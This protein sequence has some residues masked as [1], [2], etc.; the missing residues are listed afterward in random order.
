[1]TRSIE[2]TRDQVGDAGPPLP[3]SAG[4][5]GPRRRAT[6]TPASP[7]EG[8]P[9]GRR[10][11]GVLRRHP[12]R[13][14]G[15]AVVVALVPGS[16]S[17]G[18]ALLNP[19]LGPSVPAR[20]AEWT[21]DHGGSS[22][23]DGIENYW[24]SHHPPPVG[25]RPALGEIPLATPTISLP[26]TSPWHLP[27]P[28][29][30]TPLAAP[31]LPDE[32]VWHPAGRLVSGVPAIYEAFL[33]PD[34]V[35]TS[36]V[37][38]VAW[39]D[40]K[41]LRARL[42]SGSYIPGGGPYH[43]TAPV[44]PD[45]A[46]SLDAAFNAGFRMNQANGGYYTDDETVL[47]LRAGAASFVIYADGSVDIGAWDRDVSMNS[48]VASVRQN[49][50]LLVDSGR[51][52]AGLQANDD[53]RWGYTLGNQ[54]YVWR[55]GIGITANGAL[56]YVGGPGLNITT[57][58][59]LLVRAGADRAM[60]LDINTAWVNFATFA[61]AAPGGAATASSGKDLLADMNGQPDRYFAS[62]WERDFFTMS[63]APG[64]GPGA[65]ASGPG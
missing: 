10:R 3:S 26:A 43:Y 23:V 62:N 53:S 40:T 19:S 60:E 21:R 12:F 42:Y 9:A 52:V 63:L 59:D 51:P 47:P 55:S 44:G 15:V 6:P 8:E 31:A 36:L 49:L 24:Y 13:S 35:H 28:A 25:G 33:R 65:A 1:V 7:P 56:V 17:L 41:L 48:Q 27:A 58:A 22:I 39:M 57:L 64:A 14:A 37:A 30:L 34:P 4:P 16:I 46:T 20:L 11:R 18:Q 54:V 45:V 50:D 5:G 32:G 61:P 2:A 38:G 29:A